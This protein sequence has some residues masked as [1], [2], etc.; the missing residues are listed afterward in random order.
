[1]KFPWLLSLAATSLVYLQALHGGF[2]FDDFPNIVENSSIHL[3]S[4]SFQG[5]VGSLTGA[6]AGPLGRPVSVLS[7]ALTYLYFGL[8]PYAFKAINLA[9]HLTNGLL[10]GW[11]VLLLVRQESI[12]QVSNGARKWLPVWVATAWLLHPIHFVAINMA[13]QRMTLLAAMFMLLALITHMKA[14]YS[15]RGRL[16]NWGWGIFAWGVFWPLAV[17]SKETGLLFPI[18]AMLLT[19][20]A[21]DSRHHA[22]RGNVRLIALTGGAVALVAIG[23]YWKIGFLWLDAGYSVRDFTMYERLLTQTRVL[24]FYLGQTLLPNHASFALYLDWFTVSRGWFEPESTFFAVLAW[25][26]TISTV[27]RYRRHQPAL[28]F[29]LAWFLLG[30]SMES[31]FVPLE[32]AHEHRNYLPALGAVLTVG[33]VGARIFDQLSFKQSKLVPV[34]VSLA[35]LIVLGGLTCLRSAQMSDPQIG[36]QIEAT[37][38]E[39]SARANYV[40]ALTLIRAG[41]GDGDDSMGAKNIR[42]Y[43]E[44]AERSDR[45]FK[46]GY[47][48]LIVWACSS[49]RPVDGLWLDG[50]SGS[51]ENTTFAYGQFSLPAALTKAFAVMPGCLARNDVLRLFEAGSRN[52]RV[53]GGI[54][55]RFLE[56][57][58]D[59][60]LVVQRDPVSANN[61]YLRAIELDAGNI[62]LRNK[63]KDLTLIK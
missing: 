33:I 49:E 43:L 13:V 7:F 15:S 24:W 1:M 22:H 18:F 9:I 40:A 8:D 41:Y 37:R 52:F 61:Y 16:L 26:V 5:L 36:A 20:F 17:L 56:G 23:M 38:H 51:L 63:I 30:H 62:G 44:Q 53:G 12:L 42:F 54:R 32:I 3:A 35:T 10:V 34:S 55:A 27:I 46:L 11:F 19:F 45:G 60:E 47:L 6:S 58:A 57:A 25:G 4:L 14:V 39:T 50:F 2:L 48:A 28:V 59:Y 21:S 31:T 29:G